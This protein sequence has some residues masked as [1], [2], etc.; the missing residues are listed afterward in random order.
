MLLPFL[1]VTDALK[2]WHYPYVLMRFGH[3]FP[4]SIEEGYGQ[5]VLAH[6]DSVIAVVH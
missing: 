3:S 4:H 5:N 2:Q 6:M 1:N